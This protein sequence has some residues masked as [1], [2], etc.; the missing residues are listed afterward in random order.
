MKTLLKRLAKGGIATFVLIVL[1]WIFFWFT[2]NKYPPDINQI[3]LGNAPLFDFNPLYS[4]SRITMDLITLILGI[5]IPY[6][7]FYEIE[8]KSKAKKTFKKIGIY[9]AFLVV[10]LNTFFSFKIYFIF[11]I[12]VILGI[13]AGFSSKDDYK[14]KYSILKSELNGQYSHT[15]AVSFILNLF[16]F[17]SIISG[18]IDASILSFLLFFVF[19]LTIYLI[20][21]AKIISK[22]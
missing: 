5:V 18:P 13:F 7:I 4:I 17:K 19:S 14:K 3:S 20:R 21:L 15:L 6:F 22:K 8:T 2:E 10:F 16:V 9:L 1:Y 12:F 11:I